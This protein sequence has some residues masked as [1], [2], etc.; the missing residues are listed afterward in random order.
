MADDPTYVVPTGR[1]Y[2]ATYAV[3]PNHTVLLSSAA[4]EAGAWTAAS[5]ARAVEREDGVAI[6][7]ATE[8][9]AEAETADA[10]A[11]YALGRRHNGLSIAVGQRTVDA[12]GLEPADDVR[13]YGLATD[14]C[15]DADDRDDSDDRAGVLL[16]DAADDPRVA[17]DRDCETD[18]DRETDP[19]RDAEAPR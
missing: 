19:D 9:D 5:R 17:T 6:V 8:A 15:D 18:R 10:I 16:V 1:G 14:D 12:L 2:R 13:V 3:T 7:P 11:E 4:L